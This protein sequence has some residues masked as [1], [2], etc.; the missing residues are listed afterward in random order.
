MSSKIDKLRFFSDEDG[1]VTVD[2]VVI[3]AA[4]VLFGSA[5]LLVLGPAIGDG[6]DEIATRVTDAVAAALS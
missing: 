5:V 4:I 6:G 3:T 1:A 2:W